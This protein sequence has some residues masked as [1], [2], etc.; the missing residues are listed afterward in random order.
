LFIKK[1]KRKKKREPQQQLRKKQKLKKNYFGLR[2]ISKRES[3]AP[4]NAIPLSKPGDTGRF[5]PIKAQPDE[6]N[7]YFYFLA[8]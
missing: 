2:F 6:G 7:C 5:I 4:S 3:K 8:I 1:K